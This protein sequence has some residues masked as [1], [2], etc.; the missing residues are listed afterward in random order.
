MAV[1]LSIIGA[2]ASGAVG[3]DVIGT[4][5]L[6]G[7]ITVNTLIGAAIIIGA[8]YALANALVGRGSV[9]TARLAQ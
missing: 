7:N 2:Y 6:V 9:S 5:I 8:E 1:S 4:T 3:L